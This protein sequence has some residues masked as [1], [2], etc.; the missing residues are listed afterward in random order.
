MP[1]DKWGIKVILGAFLLL[2][3]AYSLALPLL[4]GPDEMWHYPYVQ[5]IAQGKGLPVQPAGGE[6]QEYHQPPLYYALGALLTFWIDTSDLPELMQRNPYWGY[7]ARGQ[8]YDNKN[9]FLHTDRE[10]FPWRGAVL[11]IHLVRLL[12]VA[13]GAMTVLLIYLIARETF[14]AHKTL[15]CVATAIAA[16]NPQFIHVCS[17][18]NN[19]SLTA[20][21][22]SLAL[23]LMIKLGK[24]KATSGRLIAL[25]VTLGLAFLTKWSTLA[26]ALLLPLALWWSREKGTPFLKALVIVLGVALLVSGW[27]FARNL[28]LYGDPLGITRKMQNFPPRS[29]SPGLMDLLRELPGKEA[30]FWASFGWEN[31]YADPW[32][33]K[34]LRAMDVFALAGLALFALLRR[35]RAQGLCLRCLGL[36]ALWLGLVFASFLRWMVYTEAAVGRH[37]FP[38]LASIALLWAW[39]LHQLWPRAR[40]EVLAGAGLFLLALIS[41]FRYIAS[42]YAPPPLFP[43]QALHIVP[44]RLDAAFGGKV[45]L[46]GYE[47]ESREVRPGETLRITLYWQALMP[48]KENYSVFVHL[49]DEE[50]LILA[51]RDTYPG[52]GNYPTSVWSPG[53]IVRDTYPVPIPLTAPSPSLV[54]PLVGLYL[55]STMQ[56]LPLAGGGDAIELPAVRIIPPTER[57]EGVPNPTFL[58]LDGKVALVGYELPKRTLRPGDALRLTLYWKA[59]SRP[60]DDYVVFVHLIGPGNRIWAQ[61]DSPPRRG[62]Y[63]TSRWAE[64]EVI[65]DTYRLELPLEMPPGVYNLE[66]GMCRA[67]GSRL[68][69]RSREGGLLGDHILLPP[70]RVT[71]P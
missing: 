52:L 21:L 42:A 20:A 9:I 12:S 31:V 18:V 30:S 41:P 66:I 33:Y 44:N 11:A 45:K 25:G 67:D 13:F 60:G 2:G 40:L 70:L 23:F 15:A 47:L 27:W 35:A 4:E 37:L 56:R 62:M 16:F 69:V 49:I 65:E 36:L 39:G 8:E 6:K 34:A 32:V 46:L 28:L 57:V 53:V 22:S 10:R 19:D 58:S 14:P 68:K 24:G 48:M 50:G 3:V 64:G 55:L 43:P 59:L 29:P 38:A 17:T 26:L 61:R 1:V 7:H 51:Q 54:R 5:H 71:K 63:P